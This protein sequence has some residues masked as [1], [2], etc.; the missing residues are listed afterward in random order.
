MKLGGEAGKTNYLVD[1]SRF[2]TDGYRDHSATT[3][4]TFNGKVKFDLS[5]RSQLTVIGNYLDQPGTE[6]PLG[7]TAA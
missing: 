7:L 5:D 2:E 6:D 3:R 4:D 1:L